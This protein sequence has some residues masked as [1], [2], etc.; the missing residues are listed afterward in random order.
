MN[1][2]LLHFNIFSDIDVC[3]FIAMKD[4]EIMRKHFK[5]LYDYQENV[6]KMGGHKISDVSEKSGGATSEDAVTCQGNIAGNKSP[7]K[8]MQTAGNNLKASFA[9]TSSKV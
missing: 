3:Q 1:E 9:S 4:K 5:N 7:V 6:Y 2:L 8:M